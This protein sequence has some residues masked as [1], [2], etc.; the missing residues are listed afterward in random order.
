[1]SYYVPSARYSPLR[2][3][4]DPDRPVR[5][6]IIGTGI[7]AA[8]HIPVFRQLEDTEIFAIGSR[9][10]ERAKEMADRHRIDLPSDDYREIVDH[11]DVDAVVIATPPYLHHSIAIAAIEAGKHV[12]CE[13]PMAR[14]LAEARDMVNLAR[15]ADVAAVVNH[16]YRYMPARHHVKTI[17]DEGFLGTPQSASIVVYRSSL[18]DPQGRP[19]SWLMERDKAGGMLAASGSHYIDLLRWWFGD[20]KAVAGLTATMVPQR[21]LPDSSEMAHVDAD[22]NFALM[23]RFQNGAIGTIH[24]CAT[25]A[26]DAGEEITLSGSAGM[27]LLQGDGALWGAR[28]GDAGLFEIDVPR[29]PERKLPEFGHI[30]ARPTALLAM[31]WVRA[32]RTGEPPAQLPTFE[33]GARVQEIIDGVHRSSAQGRWIDTSGTRWPVSRGF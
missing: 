13:K 8:V 5:V 25:A 4:V 20:I 3:E 16:E 27:I 26:S 12:L 30:L 9:R 17:I 18:A 19:F 29:G 33:D 31:D 21:H 32:I 7:G 15:T 24:V 28:R 11:P 22:D 10:I 1:V 23:L 6:A 14:N 2:V